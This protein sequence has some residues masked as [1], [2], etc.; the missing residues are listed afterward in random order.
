M[1]RRCKHFH[2][3][4]WWNAKLNVMMGYYTCNI[5]CIKIFD[6]CKGCYKYEVQELDPDWKDII[7]EFNRRLSND[8]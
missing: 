8:R 3:L 1:T 6:R 2:Y 4:K 7:E 5:D